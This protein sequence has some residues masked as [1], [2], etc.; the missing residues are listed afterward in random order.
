[1]NKFYRVYDCWGAPIL[2]TDSASL[3][4]HIFNQFPGSVVNGTGKNIKT[5]REVVA[6]EINN[7][8]VEIDYGENETFLRISLLNPFLTKDLLEHKLQIDL[9]EVN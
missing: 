3:G 4:K 7:V 8:P 5:F 6:H 9:E 2:N 1:M